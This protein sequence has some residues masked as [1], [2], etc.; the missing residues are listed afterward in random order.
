[1]L[2]LEPSEPVLVFQVLH[3]SLL[4]PSL[5]SSSLILTLVATATASVPLLTSTTAAT[6]PHFLPLL[7]SGL[8]WPGQWICRHKLGGN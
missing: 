5:L 6:T 2:G 8:R 3:L 1:M 4:L 7:L